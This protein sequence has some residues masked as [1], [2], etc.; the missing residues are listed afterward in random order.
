MKKYKEAFEA[1]DR[2]TS[3]DPKRPDVWGMKAET[4][5]KMGRF[6]EAITSVNNGL[7]LAPDNPVSIYNRACIYSLKGDK[8]NALADLKKAIS[9]NPALKKKA[10]KDE[11]F[12]R[13]YND[14]D[15]KKLTL[16]ASEVQVSYVIQ[17][18]GKLIPDSVYL[19][20]YPITKTVDGQ[21]LP[22]PLKAFST[23]KLSSSFMIEPGNYTLGSAAWGYTS[24]KVPI[25]FPTDEKDLN[26]KVILNPAFIGYGKIRDINEIKTVSIRGDFN[27]FQEKNEIP[28]KKTDGVW[29]PLHDPVNLRGGRY[30]FAVNGEHTIDLMN[31]KV[32]PLRRWSSVFNIYNNNELVFDPSL[33]T[34][35]LNTSE[36]ETSWEIR[37]Y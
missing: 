18:N 5:V 36:I 9:M 27:N 3:L 28:M 15:F 13:F 22:E 34:L 31:K 30:I 14:E 24:L 2:A 29:K 21:I 12:K 33:Y 1:F 35:G 23:S 11:D 6:D 10:L 8:A 4:L 37:L 19:I 25:N 26:I 32:S 20:I 16:A 7:E 17:F